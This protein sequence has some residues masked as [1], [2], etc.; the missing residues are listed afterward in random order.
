MDLKPPS[1]FT[2]KSTS[3]HENGT[4]VSLEQ[5]VQIEKIEQLPIS[6][7]KKLSLVSL[8]LNKRKVSD[9]SIGFR[10]QTEKEVRK[11]IEIHKKELKEEMQI[12][13]DSCRD[14]GLE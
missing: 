4:I 10:F 9:I 1:S 3:Q 14:I 13:V 5:K 12:L 7:S 2:N 6:P 8:I 11:N